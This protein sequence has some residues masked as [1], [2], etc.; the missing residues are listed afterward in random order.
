M[1]KDIAN[2]S[3]MVIMYKS[4][5]YEILDMNSH[6][7]SNQRLTIDKELKINIKIK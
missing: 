6:P 3:N 1:I 5:R 2:F 4:L 7:Q